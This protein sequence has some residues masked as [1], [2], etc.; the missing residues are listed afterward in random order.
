MT[1]R[2]QSP[3]SFELS[4]AILRFAKKVVVNPKLVL[5]IKTRLDAGNGG[6]GGVATPFPSLFH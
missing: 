5:Y 4:A 6:M 3:S 2:V 1:F